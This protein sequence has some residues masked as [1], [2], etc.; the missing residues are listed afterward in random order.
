MNSRDQE[1]V[2]ETLIAPLKSRMALEI[3]WNGENEMDQSKQK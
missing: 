3:S 2:N 1:I